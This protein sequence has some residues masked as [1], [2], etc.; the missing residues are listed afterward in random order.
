M[1]LTR[2]EKLWGEGGATGEPPACGAA[3]TE[4]REAG[5]DAAGDEPDDRAAAGDEP[6]ARTAAGAEPDE[7]PITGA[8]PDTSGG[9]STSPTTSTL[10]EDAWRVPSGTAGAF[11]L[12]DS[13]GMLGIRV[14]S[15]GRQRNGAGCTG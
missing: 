4:E 2:P 6:D 11:G 3:G 7:R 1:E 15:N 8:E 5:L 12:E 13:S 14:P 10:G 9:T